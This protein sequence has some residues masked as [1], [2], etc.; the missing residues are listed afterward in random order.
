MFFGLRNGGPGWRGSSCSREVNVLS[1]RD[2]LSF[3]TTADEEVC[4]RVRVFLR[5]LGKPFG[6]RPMRSRIRESLAVDVVLTGSASFSDDS[7][8]LD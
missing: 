1:S 3:P 8:P 5:T 2:F 7:E 4:S 6:A